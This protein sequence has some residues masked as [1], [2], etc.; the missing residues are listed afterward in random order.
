MARLLR[1]LALVAVLGGLAV[2]AGSAALQWWEP[3][4]TAPVTADVVANPRE[5][6]RVEVLN[7]GGVA[8]MAREATEVLRDGGFD[9]VEFGNADAFD[10]D[11][12]VVLARLGRVDLAS[13]VADALAIST[14]ENEAD[15]TAYVDVT[16]LLGSTWNPAILIEREAE[17]AQDTTAAPPPEPGWRGILS[18]LR[19][20]ADGLNQAGSQR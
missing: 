15:S 12:S 18:R 3:P 5:R 9:V 4:E 7:A 20:W 14:Y 10:R 1:G 17:R 19:E 16:V 2:L 11:S 6:V 13:M 8:G